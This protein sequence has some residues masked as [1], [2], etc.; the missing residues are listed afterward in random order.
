MVALPAATPVTTPVEETVATAA[1]LLLHIPA[2]VV[3]VSVVE[4]PG[5]TDAAPEIAPTTGLVQVDVT[6]PITLRP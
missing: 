5:Q 2:T 1:L 3:S 6:L 4:A